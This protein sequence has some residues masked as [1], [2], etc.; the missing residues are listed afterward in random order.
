MVDE[1][2][3]HEDAE[4]VS[5]TLWDRI[6]HHK[7]AVVGIAAI[8]AVVA[9][10]VILY[11]TFRSRARE[12][13][14]AEIIDTSL[15]NPFGAAPALENLEKHGG[16]DIL[17]HVLF[18]KAKNAAASDSYDEALAQLKRLQDEHPDSYLNTLPA[19]EKYSLVDEFRRWIELEKAWQQAHTYK[20]PT[21]NTDRVA[22]VETS[23]GAF[24]VGFYPEMAP[25]H[26]EHFL[27]QAK[28]GTFNGTSITELK[29]TR[30]EFGGAFSRDD[31][32]FNDTDPATDT[33]LAPED[34]R[35]TIRPER[36]TVSFAEVEGGASP[37][38]LTVAILEDVELDKRQTI[39]GRVLTDRFPNL[40]TLDAIAKVETYGSS[41]DPAFK[42]SEKYGKVEDHPVKSVKIERVSIWAQDKLEDGHQWDTAS[43]VKPAPKAPAEPP[44]DKPTDKPADQ[45]ADK[46]VEEKPADSPPQTPGGTEPGK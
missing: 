20:S 6:E 45:P 42:D 29:S 37:T 2:L 43:V 28:A 1:K 35:F 12:E 44:A 27:A 33:P 41:A 46:P 38:R 10:G 32:P 22:L 11:A 25:K 40:E 21:V 5:I 17:P 15:Y 31:D 26:V 30:F 24:W 23:M 13:R 7:K 8:V 3:K 36:G 4:Q 14:W 9:V 18:L 19:S 39:F 34:A 16:S